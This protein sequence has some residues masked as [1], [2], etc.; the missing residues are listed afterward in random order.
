MGDQVHL[1]EPWNLH[2]PAIGLHRNVMLQQIARLGPS[3][4]APP[5]LPLLG[6][7][8]AVDLPRADLQQLLLDLRPHSVALANPRH[9]HRQQR[10]QPHRPGIAGRLPYGGQKGQRFPAV[11]QPPPP[12]PPCAAILGPRPV[13]QTD[14]VFPVIACVGTKL[15][16]NHVLG[17]SSRRPIA[18]INRPQ[19]LPSPLIP[20]PTPPPSFDLVG[21]HLKWR[22]VAPF[23][24]ILRGAIRTLAQNRRASTI[25]ETS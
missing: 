8:P 3:V 16:Q 23:G 9:P 10:L 19:V 6:L 4:D 18:L 22:D 14:G 12:L 21:L 11:T 2:I 24:Y 15:T 17:L 7:Q 5:A 13:Q 25:S 20:Q 1:R